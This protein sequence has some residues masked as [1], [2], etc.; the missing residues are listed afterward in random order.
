VSSAKP[1]QSL[2]QVLVVEDDSSIALGLRINLEAEG[3]RVAVAADGA[4]GLL[5]ARAGCD[6]MILD[7]MIPGMNGFELLQTLRSE[8]WNTPTIILSALSAEADKVTGLDL[9]AE[10][11]VTKPFSLA[12]LLARIRSVFRRTRA[13]A[14]AGL[15]SGQAG[16]WRLGP[17]I[18]VD[19]EKREV[20]REGDAVSL[21]R[22]EFEILLALHRAQGSVL[23]RADLI[24]AIWGPDHRVT[25][26]TVDNF[27]AQLRAKL[28]DAE[29]PKHL[30]TVR[31]VG[32][33]LEL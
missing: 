18:L 1:P 10:D 2:A 12:E 5:A 22:T 31:G 26:R 14:E 8:G 16:P 13:Q 33:R 28:D 11:Y 7:L 23:S 4:A 3:Y 17:S 9:G 21:T 25:T 19:P 32:Y 15:P 6:L 27:L 30:I 29:S 20:T 24:S